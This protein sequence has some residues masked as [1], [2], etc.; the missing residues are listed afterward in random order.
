MNWRRFEHILSFCIP[1]LSTYI[2][3][4][5]YITIFMKDNQ[6]YASQYQQSATATLKFVGSA[7]YAR[8]G[9][10]AKRSFICH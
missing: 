8:L 9:K 3:I 2:Y 1:T 6:Y 10:L 7:Y 5:I 4:Y